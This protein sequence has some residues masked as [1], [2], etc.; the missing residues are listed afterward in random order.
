MPH[1]RYLINCPKN[2]ICPSAKLKQFTIVAVVVALL[3]SE[4]SLMYYSNKYI[5]LNKIEKQ[6]VAASNSNEKNIEVIAET[7]K[8]FREV[9]DR[10]YIGEI[11]ET[12][13]LDETIKGYVKQL[14][15]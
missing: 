1:G 11:D 6:Q 4:L 14:F 3:S 10:E 12:K 8:S 13:V 15:G 7:L 2:L 9:I 5:D